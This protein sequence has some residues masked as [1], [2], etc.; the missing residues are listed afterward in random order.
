MVKSARRRSEAVAWIGALVLVVLHLDFW[1]AQE[2]RLVLGWMPEDLA[3][4][5]CWMILATAYLFWFTARIWK[6]GE[7][8]E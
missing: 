4:R 7:D 2:A 6:R 1:R 3:Y 8:G 5:L